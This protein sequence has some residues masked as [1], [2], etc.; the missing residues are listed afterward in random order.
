M[1]VAIRSSET[2]VLTRTTRR[3][4]PEDV[5]LQYNSISA[6]PEMLR[7]LSTPRIHFARRV[8][9]LLV[10]ANVV[11]SSMISVTL[12]MEVLRSSETPLLQEPHDVTCQ[13]T[14]FFVVFIIICTILFIKYHLYS[15]GRD[16]ISPL[17]NWPVQLHRC[18]VQC[19]NGSGFVLF[20]SLLVL[21][22]ATSRNVSGSISDDVTEFISW[23]NPCIRTLAPGSTQPLTATST[24]NF[25]GGEGLKGGRPER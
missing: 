22:T 20:V 12:M 10:T 2:S 7:V 11:P 24:V 16:I 1:M 4:I 17:L 9:R 15:K 5:I 14:A 23:P 13:K 25:S 18:S 21:R 8:H 3:S 19:L 6:N